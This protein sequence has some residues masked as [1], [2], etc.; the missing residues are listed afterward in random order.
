MSELNDPT[1]PVADV[2]Y[3]TLDEHFSRDPFGLSDA[4]L[5]VIVAELRRRRSAWLLEEAKP[6]PERATKRKA[7]QEEIKS[8]LD[9]I[10]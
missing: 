1:S 9:S 7:S 3:N 10:L 5:D 8:V 2:N 6:K 4:D